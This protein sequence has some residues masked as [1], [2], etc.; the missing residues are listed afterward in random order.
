MARPYSID[1]RE[2]VVAAVRSGQTSRGV[3]ARFG[4]VVSAVVKW[5]RRERET[6]TVAP[7]RMGGHR[8]PILA[9]HRNWLIA[10]VRE[11]P[12]ITLH[13]L[14]AELRGRGVRVSHDTVWRFLR[15]EG[16]SFKKKRA[17]L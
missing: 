9:A 11:T 17:G 8:K 16:L 12:E 10:R 15:G 2:R 5:S 3:A 14:K 1:L 7:G 13:A 6:G 4:V